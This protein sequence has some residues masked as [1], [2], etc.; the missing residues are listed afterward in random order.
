[1][2]IPSGNRKTAIR[3]GPLKND[4]LF[5]DS[6]FERF[7]QG[8]GALIDKPKT[9]QQPPPDLQNAVNSGASNPNN[10]VNKLE[11]KG[12]PGLGSPSS[13]QPT[14]TSQNAD[15][16][17]GEFGTPNMETSQGSP[18]MQFLGQDPDAQDTNADPNAVFNEEGQK[19]RKFVG[20]D[21]GMRLVVNP[22]KTVTVT[23]KPPANT[24]MQNPS[25]FIDQLLHYIGGAS[26][27]EA[28]TPSATDS[29][30]SVTL[31]YRPGGAPEKI[32]PRGKKG[33]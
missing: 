29:N 21:F 19:I 18:A 27:N 23:L 11:Q 25:G 31:K 9:Q 16:I 12:Q 5:S 33:Y 20:N 13:V 14:S 28:D 8:A 2:I 4:S 15:Q 17:M 24:P 3:Q 6:L 7:A 26:V 22:D 10:V 32:R 30:G 1:M